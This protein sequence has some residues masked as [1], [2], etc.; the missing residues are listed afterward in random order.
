A[1]NGALHG[2]RIES[3]RV[4]QPA[5]PARSDVRGGVRRRGRAPAGREAVSLGRRI[6]TDKRAVVIPLAA[7]GLVNILGD[8]LVR[9]SLRTKSETA[10]DRAAAAATSR[11]AAQRDVGAA[12]ALVT[13]KT[14]ADQ[15][16]ATFYK[17][18]LPPDHAAAQ[19]MTYGRL[20]ALAKKANVKYEQ[21]TEEI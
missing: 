9:Y 21:R 12:Q 16:L 4:L 19:R 14:Q 6:L 8:A 11:Q 18:V 15:E 7:G 20:P 1:G 3:E 17:K 5:G 13:G 10:A 2:C